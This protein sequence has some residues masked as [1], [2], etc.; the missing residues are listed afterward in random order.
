MN[1][2]VIFVGF[3][4]ATTELSVGGAPP[5]PPVEE[6]VEALTVNSFDVTFSHPDLSV[7][8]MDKLKVP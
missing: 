7:A 4:I 3:F 1:V 5:P 6:D 2:F 8:V